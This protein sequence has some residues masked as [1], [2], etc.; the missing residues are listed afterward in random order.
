[1][2]AETTRGIGMKTFDIDG[3]SIPAMG[4]G[5]WRLRST[6]CRDMVRFALEIGYRHIDTAAI[7]GNEEEVGR[8]IADSGV[9]RNELFLT[10]KVWPSKLGAEA[11]K[12]SATE[13][14]D[15][16]GTDYVDLLLIHWPTTSVPLIETFGAMRDLQQEGRVRHLGVSN[17]NVALMRETVET[18]NV[19]IVANQV[20]YHPYLSQNRVLDY[21]QRAGITLTAYCPV[22]EGR[23]AKDKTLR[24]IGA[25]YERSAAEVA[26]RW[27]LHQDM[28]SV[29]PMTTNPEHCMANLKVL[30]FSLTPEDMA[31]IAA[32]AEGRRLID[33]YSGFAWDAD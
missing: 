18:L 33:M 23:A 15:R 9:P 6:T 32:L 13:S 11:L 4:F 27:L 24:R 20:E 7:Y 17:F 1:M 29:I 14:L 30:D 21:C 12:R 28:V 22:A 19:P 26:L 31:E 5:T 8:A 2:G 3:A 25:N 10:T 16:L